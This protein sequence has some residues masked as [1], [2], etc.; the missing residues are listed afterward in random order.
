MQRTD[1]RRLDDRQQAEDQRGHA[2]DNHTVENHSAIQHKGD[3]GAK[4]LHQVAYEVTHPRRGCRPHNPA[5]QPQQARFQTKEQVEVLAMIPRRFQH[6]NL[7]L[8]A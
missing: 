8:A 3:V 4:V 5:D 6:C 1:V 7:C 2:A